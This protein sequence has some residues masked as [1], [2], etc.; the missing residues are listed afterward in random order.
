MSATPTS[1]SSSS[2]PAAATRTAAAGA[3]IGITLAG[4]ETIVVIGDSITQQNLYTAFLETFLIGRFPAKQLTFWNLGWGGDVAPGGHGRFA[5]DVLGLKPSTVIV[6]F[7]M[8]D[9]SYAPPNPEVTARWFQGITD[10]V[11]D[12]R[13]AGARPILMTTNPVDERAAPWLAR[14]NETLGLF[15]RMLAEYAASEGIALIDLFHPVLAVQQAAQARSPSI[16]LA[17][18]GVHPTAVGHLV[19]AAAAFSSFATPPALGTLLI[20]P[21][22]ITSDGPVALSALTVQPQ[23]IS[24][25]LDL[26]YLPFWVPSE[27]REALTLIALQLELNRFVLRA[28]GWP[29]QANLSVRLDGVEVAVLAPAEQ[30]AGLDLTTLEQAPW[31]LQGQRLWAQAQQRFSLHFTAWRS[32]ALAD[33]PEAQ[34]LPSHVQLLAAMAAYLHE[35]PTVLRQLAQPRRYHLHCEI[36]RELLLSVA[37]LSP[38]YPFAADRPEDF[39]TRHAP[40]TAPQE[41]LW[42]LATWRKH[43]I[44]LGVHFGAPSNCVC[45]ARIRLHAAGVSR[46]RLLLGSDD[47]LSVLLNG[48]RVLDRNVFRGC[49]LGDDA[50][51]IALPEG[52]SELLLRVT[53]GGGGYGVAMKMLLLA[54][55]RVVQVLPSSVPP[56]AHF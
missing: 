41:V 29:D 13:R 9:G 44:D 16:T 48:R 27:A 50:C 11:A 4:R 45:Y 18:D 42:T 46:V 5:R 7:G 53:Q 31:A 12:I 32:L 1:S 40:E 47:G 34:A 14:Y 39:A 2:E 35:S 8:N 24:C 37:E 25:A 19:M 15:A 22:G 52:E 30:A 55:A 3:A 20:T 56:A 51:E 21:Q 38:L 26:P 54:G 6:N 28:S 10:L 33:P 23:A 43:A 17:P 49:R 36:S